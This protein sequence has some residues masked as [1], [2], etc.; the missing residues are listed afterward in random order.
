[1]KKYEEDVESNTLLDKIDRL[2][3]MSF[4]VPNQLNYTL[5]EVRKRYVAIRIEAAQ[6]IREICKDLSKDE[7]IELITLGYK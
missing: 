2:S 6:E 1:M 5:E 7:I 4:N 3:Y